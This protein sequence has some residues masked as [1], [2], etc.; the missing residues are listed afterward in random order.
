MQIALFAARHGMNWINLGLPPA[1]HSTAGSEAD[2]NRLCSWLGA[3]APSNT[4]KGPDLAP[5]EAD[6]ATARHLGRRVATIT[7]QF[8]RGRAA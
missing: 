5:P 3:R 4:D 7:L 6:F 8:A 2:P 1:N